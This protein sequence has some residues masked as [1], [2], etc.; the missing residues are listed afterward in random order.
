MFQL[1]APQT[2]LTHYHTGTIIGGTGGGGII[3]GTGG[4]GVARPPV[5]H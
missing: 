4:T 3:P 1:P 2:K 5:A